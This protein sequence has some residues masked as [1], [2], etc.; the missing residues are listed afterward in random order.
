MPSFYGARSVVEV[1]DCTAS[2]IRPHESNSD[3]LIDKRNKNC[4]MHRTLRADCPD[5]L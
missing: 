1:T 4:G 5:S 3:L 2:Q